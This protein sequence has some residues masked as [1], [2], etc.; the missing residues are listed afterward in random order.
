MGKIYNDITET[1]GNTPLVQLR[2]VAPQGGAR[3]FIKLEY[4]NPTGSY[5]DRMARSVIECAERRGAL[6]LGYFP[7][8][9][10][11]SPTLF[12]TLPLNFSTVPSS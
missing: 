4:Y 2:R 9:F 6:S 12:S 11:T 8:T 7:K 1:I 10:F 5:K 3:V